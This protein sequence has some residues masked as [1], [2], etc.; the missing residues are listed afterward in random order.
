MFKMTEVVLCLCF[1]QLS[2]AGLCSHENLTNWSQFS[3]QRPFIISPYFDGDL[4]CKLF[5]RD[6]VP[7]F[8]EAHGLGADNVDE[9]RVHVPRL[10]GV[11]SKIFFKNIFLS[12]LLSLACC[13]G[14]PCGPSPPAPGPRSIPPWRGSAEPVCDTPHC[15]RRCPLGDKH[16]Q[17]EEIMSKNLPSTLPRI[18]ALSSA[19]VSPTAMFLLGSA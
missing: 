6:I 3:D 13:R 14:R 1:D 5:G 16:Q 15:P 17:S 11:S 18:T 7:E 10:P 12:S 8:E 4:L 9:A 2:I 19:L